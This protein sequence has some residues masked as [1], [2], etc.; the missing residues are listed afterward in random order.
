METHKY[1]GAFLARMNPSRIP[2]SSLLE[3][4]VEQAKIVDVRMNAIRRNSMFAIV[5]PHFLRF[6]ALNRMCNSGFAFK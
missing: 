6:P 3:Y 1:R 5:D 2:F 4:T